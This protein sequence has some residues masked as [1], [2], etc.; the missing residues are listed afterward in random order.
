MLIR[1]ADPV[2]AWT[3]RGDLENA[4]QEEGSEEGDQEEEVGPGVWLVEGGVD[5]SPSRSLLPD[6][7]RRSKP[8]AAKKAKK[9]AK[10]KK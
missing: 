3:E 9:A 5:R 1:G 10:K 8:M 6:S 2:H 4:G 7:K